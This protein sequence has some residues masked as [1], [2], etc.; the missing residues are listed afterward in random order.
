MKISC[1]QILSQNLQCVG[2]VGGD[3]KKNG[4]KKN[5]N[6]KD[7]KKKLSGEFRSHILEVKRVCKTLLY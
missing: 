1:L 2:G 5:S 7:I 6:S 3:K 4:E